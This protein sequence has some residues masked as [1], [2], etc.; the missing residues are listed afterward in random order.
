MYINMAT[1]RVGPRTHARARDTHTHTHTPRTH[2]HLKG[3]K[4]SSYRSAARGSPPLPRALS[5]PVAPLGSWPTGNRTKCVQSQNPRITRTKGLAPSA[6]PIQYLRMRHRLAAGHVSSKRKLEAP[7][8]DG[9]RS[10]SCTQ[11]GGFE[12]RNQK[13]HTHRTCLS[14]NSGVVGVVGVAKRLQKMG[15]GDAT[16]PQT[17]VRLRS[18]VVA[19]HRDVHEAWQN[20]APPNN[21]THSAT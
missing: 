10:W 20:I 11:H 2:T 1:A 21:A 17:P 4:L 5:S 8:H 15:R 16:T 9:K 3:A 13:L 12:Q 6:S 18:G 14:R 19:K 7:P